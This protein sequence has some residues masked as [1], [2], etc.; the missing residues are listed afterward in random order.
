MSTREQARK[1]KRTCRVV[2]PATGKPCGR[3]YYVESG[4]KSKGCAECCP[5]LPGLEGS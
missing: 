5:R 1:V 3:V 2:Q 4:A